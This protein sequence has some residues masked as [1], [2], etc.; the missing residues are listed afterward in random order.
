MLYSRASEVVPEVLHE[1]HF[2]G[3]GENKSLKVKTIL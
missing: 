2:G 1:Q 3:G